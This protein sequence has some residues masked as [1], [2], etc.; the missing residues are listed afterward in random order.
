MTRQYK[1]KE[2]TAHTPMMQQYLHIKAQHQNEL[3]LYRMGDFYEL[4]FDDAVRAAKLLDITLTARGQSNGKPIPMAGVPYHAAENYIA[5]LVKLGE[6]IAICE[7]I[8]DPATSKG[9]VERKVCRIITPGTVTDEAYLDARHENLI[10]AIFSQKQ[11]FGLAILELSTGRFTIAECQDFN[12]LE[13]ELT[14]LK[15]AELLIAEGYQLPVIDSLERC[16]IKH[17]QGLEFDLT[18]AQ[19]R[20][21]EHFHVADLSVFNINSDQTFAI[22]AAGC[23][24]NYVQHT[25]RGALPHIQKI[26]IESPSESIQ[27][28]A[29]TRRNLE[30]T[31]NLLGREQ[32]TL[33][34][35]LDHSATAM[36]SRLL[37]RWLSRPLRDRNIL[38]QRLAAVRLLKDQQA[39][40]PLAKLLAQVS[41]IER[42]SSR[43]ALLSARP[44][45]LLR[46]AD[47]LEQLPLIQKIVQKNKTSVLLQTLLQELYLLP[48]LLQL[49]RRAILLECPQLIRDGGV[50]ATGYDSELDRLRTIHEDADSYMQQ[51]EQTER[52]ATGLSTLKVGY[53]RV[54]GFYI[55]LSRAQSSIVPA[56][57]RRRQT[58]KNAERFI[59]PEL[60]NF[61]DQVLS[62]KDRALSREKF[63]YEEL[64]QTIKLDLSK[65][66]STSQALA[67]LD[68]LQNFA[69]IADRLHYSC[70]E[71]T[72]APGV[73]IKAGRHPVV[74][75]MQQNA[76]VPN[77]C[78]L[79]NSTQ[80]YIVTGPNMGGKSTY[81]RQIALIVLLAHIGSFVPAAQA[82]IGPIDQIFT[83]I[84]ATDDLAAG[85]S[86]FMVEMLEAANIL[87][88]ATEQSLVLMDEIGRGTSTYDGMALAWAI[89][90]QLATHNKALTLFATH[91][92]EISKLPEEISTVANLHFDA[93][94]QNDKL[95][96]MHQALPGPT[97]KS[98]GLQVARLAGIA[99]SVIKIA[100]DKL[101]ELATAASC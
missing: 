36:G 79:N 88:N 3:L 21:C 15:P 51:L 87:N 16:A 82:Q 63:L 74:E 68:V 80:M 31:Q 13:A 58:L 18:A 27:I 41:D 29:H 40:T 5:R 99:N 66:Q 83:R 70:P 85:R 45:D 97:N 14:R 61:E 65:L 20:L 35:V 44:R 25:Q 24:L 78:M 54:H 12:T 28:D 17:R 69:A 38:Q 7:Q 91:Y 56:H 73:N 23:L 98:F 1:M 76:F 93:V 30:L 4:F 34:H 43:I 19:Q 57:Y 75:Y 62:S 2:A 96:F 48:D 84:G 49:I 39:Y 46:L 90:K 59:T 92:F 72:T 86:T 47:T 95:I 64:L 94:E 53:N 22:R 37:Q 6:T 33:M 8:G 55:E 101:Q 32:H 9:P 60:K 100:Q 42:I 50:I 77:D 89:A 81:M 10:V 52:N 67:T 26:A 11:R 71:F